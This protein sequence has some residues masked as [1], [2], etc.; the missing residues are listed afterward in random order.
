MKHKF[1]LIDN[2]KESL[3]HAVYHLTDSDQLSAGDLKRAVLDVAHVVELLL[4]ERLR[5]IH[6]AF[7]WNDV[8]KYPSEKA[9]KVDTKTAI[10]RLVKMAGVKLVDSDVKTIANCRGIRNDI[11]HYEFEI[12]PKEARVIIG[13]MLAFIFHF[14]KTHL[15]I[16]WVKEFKKD[17]RWKALIDMYEFWEQYSQTLGK[18]LQDAGK[19]VGDCPRCYAWTFVFEAMRCALCGHCE[20]QIKCEKCGELC[21]ESDIEII[22]GI[23]GDQDTGPEPYEYSICKE[24]LVAETHAEMATDEW[25]DMR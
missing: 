20:D 19:T 23:D 9:F 11:E 14:A 3:S 6:P 16:D 13:K 12:E 24:C 2:A 7:L 21:W 5:R 15:D 22:S 17:D 10:E 18:Q 8:D 25:R 1:N 4:K